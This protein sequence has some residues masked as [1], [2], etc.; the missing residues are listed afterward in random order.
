MER[1]MKKNIK[2]TT[3][4]VLVGAFYACSSE[5]TRTYSELG[6]TNYPQQF[7]MEYVPCTYGENWSTENF[8]EEM[9]PEWQNLLVETNSPLVEAFGITHENDK[10]EGVEE[11]GYWQLLWN[12]KEEAKSGWETW[13]SY[14]KTEEWAE[15]NADILVCGSQADTFSFDAYVRRDRDGLGTF[16]LSS[17]SSDYQQ[18]SYNEGQGVDELIAVIDKFEDWLVSDENSLDAP[19][20]YV[21][22]APDYETDELD[23]FW[24]NFH[25]SA[26]LREA[27]NSNFLSSAPEIQDQFDKVLSCEEP[28][29]YNSGEIPLI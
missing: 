1:K 25:Q 17:F 29:N 12:S 20:T 24:G 27:G 10:P 15:A 23:L 7:Y 6:S 2:L 11:D 4:A 8:N 3:L 9:L 28:V 16:D 19:Y 26:E 14:D 18:C 5:T 22:L 21:V 13:E